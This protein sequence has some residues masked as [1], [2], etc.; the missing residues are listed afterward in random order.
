M[1]EIETKIIDIDKDGLIAKLEKN[2]AK[3]AGKTLQKRWVFALKKAEN[4]DRFI[5]VRTDGKTA[6]VTYKYRTGSG[7]ANTEELETA[8]EDFDTAVKIF[9]KA[10][11]DGLYQENVRY[12]YIYK[13]AEITINEWPKL[14]PVV[15]VEAKSEEEVRAAISEIGIV[16]KELGNIS[17]EKV[18]AMHGMDLKS[19]KTLKFDE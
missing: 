15:E 18:Y 17:W 11:G 19:F 9:Q 3:F 6:T 1:I 4:E 13:N 7:L 10:L 14:R 2:G 8:V 16:G 5:R 12:T